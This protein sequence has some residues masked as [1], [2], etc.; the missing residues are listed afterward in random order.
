[1]ILINI[2]VIRD[3]I[4][5][6]LHAALLKYA[7]PGIVNQMYWENSSAI[8]LGI[9]W[10]SVLCVTQIGEKIDKEKISTIKLFNN[11][12]NWFSLRQK[13]YEWL[14]SEQDNYDIL[15]L[16]H[17]SAT[18]QEYFFL[19]HIK[20]PVYLVHHTLE[21]AELLSYFNVNMV[22]FGL[23]YLLESYFGKLSL[24]SAQ[25]IIC[26][27]NE[28]FDYE[29]SRVKNKF[30]NPII[31]PN[32]IFFPKN[33]SENFELIEDFKEKSI[34]EILFVAGHFSSWHGLDL[35]LD[36]LKKTKENF[37][38]HIVG[39]VDS[40]DVIKAQKDNRVILHGKMNK[41]ELQSIINESWIGLSSFA[42]FRKKMNE[43]C[44]LKVREYLLNGLPVY[45]GHKDIFPEDFIYYKSGMVDINSI[46]SFAYEMKDVNREEVV[47]YSEKFI[48][49]KN[50]LA[51][52][53][54]ELKADFN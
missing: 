10:R 53:Y 52:L 39:E 38:L 43:A 41:I 44:T 27:T 49:K 5:R 32:G 48:N 30:K 37:I 8:E 26:V 13:Y 45:S 15:V 29:N 7:S 46:L 28:I 6:V 21:Q 16:R 42:L 2:T 34:P 11:N 19:K 20:K 3:L 25:N 12:E 50:L 31:Y 54:S 1:M 51:N 33:N 24:Y 23:K 17:S 4:M 14:L 40:N 9:E 36:S 22:N 18:P 35:L 47:F